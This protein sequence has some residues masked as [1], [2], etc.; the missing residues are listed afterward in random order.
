MLMFHDAMFL[1]L[2]LALMVPVF[3]VSRVYGRKTYLLNGRLNDELE[4]ERSR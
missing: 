3:L 4:R 1:P 2:G